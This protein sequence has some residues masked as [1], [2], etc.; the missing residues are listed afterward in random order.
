[1]GAGDPAILILYPRN[2]GYYPQKQPTLSSDRDR[3]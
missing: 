3:L 2:G 1:M